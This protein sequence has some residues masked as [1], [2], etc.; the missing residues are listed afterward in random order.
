MYRVHRVE[1]DDPVAGSRHGVHDALM[2]S[3]LHEPRND[4]FVNNTTAARVPVA[5]RPH[6]PMP[7][8]VPL[9]MVSCRT[10]PLRMAVLPSFAVGEA[11]RLEAAADHAH[12]KRPPGC[13][14]TVCLPPRFQARFRHA[15]IAVRLSVRFMVGALAASPQF[16]IAWTPCSRC[17]AWWRS[18]VISRCSRRSFRRANGAVFACRKAQ[19]WRAAQLLYGVI[20]TQAMRLLRQLTAARY[21]AR[22][23]G[24]V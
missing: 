16:S 6:R 21:R 5:L 10:G 7:V 3:C 17:K 2:A 24:A 23:S 19:I 18:V 14:G 8:F 12:R 1:H 11:S 9:R 15:I 13:G 20:S 4:I 22:R